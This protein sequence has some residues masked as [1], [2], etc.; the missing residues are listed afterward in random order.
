MVSPQANAAQQRTKDYRFRR[1]ELSAFGRARISADR[2]AWLIFGVGTLATILLLV[3]VVLVWKAG[4]TLAAILLLVTM[5][6]VIQGL[7]SIY[8]YARQNFL[9]PDLAFRKWLQKVCDGELDAR[10][11]LPE[12]HRHFKELNF[13]TQ[14]LSIALSDLSNDMELLVDSQT[15]RLQN[16]KQVLELL[17]RLTSDVSNETTDDAVLETVCKYLSEWFGTATVCAYE[18]KGSSSSIVQ[19]AKNFSNAGATSDLLSVVNLP[20]RKIPAYKDI[21]YEICYENESG[22]STPLRIVV[23]YFTVGKPAGFLTID[24]DS[25]ASSAGQDTERVLR[26][27]SEQLSLFNDKSLAVEQ[28]QQARILND[29]NLLAA[30]IH[31]SL[32]QTLLATRYQVTL[33]LEKVKGKGDLPWLTELE[34]IEHAVHDANREVRDLIWQYR[35]PLSDK[36]YVQSLESLVAEFSEESGIQTFFQTGDASVEFTPAE[37]TLLNGI[38]GEVLTN[39]QK[40]SDASMIRVLLQ[41]EQSGARRLLIEDDGVGFDASL[42]DV[43]GV[44]AG[45]EKESR[46][47]HVGLEI[48]H[49]R[50]VAIGARLIVDSEP[51]DGTRVSIILPPLICPKVEQV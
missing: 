20:H 27:V 34:K 16:Q 37:E 21:P 13:H 46:A 48:M 25:E 6:V 14:N 10:I 12:Q 33:L 2:L 7:W 43:K 38:V 49:E 30:D 35:S 1:G 51:G 26:T 31:D 17:F 36:H 4:Y 8:A 11:E 19:V 23:P 32:A 29:R 44:A 9:E 47:E 50:A 3:C 41:R 45:V 24:L 42:T 18:V 28:T 22:F 40:Y 15:S 5:V 39:A